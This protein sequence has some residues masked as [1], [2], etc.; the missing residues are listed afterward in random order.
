MSQL[1]YTFYRKYFFITLGIAL[2]S[3]FL[4]WISKNFEITRKTEDLPEKLE[5][6][7][8]SKEENPDSFPIAEFNPNDLSKEQWQNLGFSERQAETILKYKNML[9]GAFS[10]K[11]EIKKCFVISDEKYAQIQPYLLL[12]EKV[13]S[14]KENSLYSNIYRK[15]ELRISGK[16][17]PDNYT[18]QEWI[19][20]GFSEKQAASIL[21]YKNYLG[22]SFISKEK[23]KECFIITDENYHKMESYLLLPEKGTSLSKATDSFAKISNVKEKIQ[24]HI[25]NPNELDLNGWMYLGFTEKQANTILNYKNKFLKG[26]FRTA[27]ELS[28]C[29]VISEEKFEEMKPYISIKEIAKEP[30]Y[31]T[32]KTEITAEN[33]PVTNFSKTDLN[34]ITF[35]QL[36]EFGFTDK[37]AGS[38]IGFRNKLGGFVSKT[39]IT[40]TYNIDKTLAEKLISVAPLYTNQVKKYKL[41]DAPESWLREHPYFKYYADKI[42]F[43]RISFPDDKKIFKNMKLKPE[44]EAK[45]KL[46]LQ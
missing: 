39:Q 9:G 7:T 40:E 22:G 46:Y 31:E 15:K 11:E 3:V 36:K 1:N 43:Y 32:A 26:Q 19:S 4:F 20:M 13:S 37:E 23:F 2:L 45:M 28:K 10:S 8:L 25:F 5:F 21:K 44:A 35:R 27:E 14:S 42:I 12:P 18:I 29:F 17:N 16:F 34:S 38:I 24:Y 41:T 30:I 33:I 6:T